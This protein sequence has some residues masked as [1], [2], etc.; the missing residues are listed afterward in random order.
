MQ[1]IQTRL[2]LSFA[3]KDVTADLLPDL[4]AFS[5]SDKETGEAD[6]LTLTMKD[7]TGKWAGSWKPTGGETVE[8][9]I[10]SGETDKKG[11]KLFCGRFYVDSQRVSGPPRVFEIS[12]VSIPLNKP[13][14]DPGAF[15]SLSCITYLLEH[16]ALIKNTVVFHSH[17]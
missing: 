1:P 15:C 10:I 8:A 3:S 11:E 13:R 14:P 12:A 9:S 4:L 17:F 7:E 16:P 6:E 5:Y 2:E